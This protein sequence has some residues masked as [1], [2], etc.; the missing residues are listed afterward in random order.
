MDFWIASSLG[1]NMNKAAMSIFAYAFG[2][3]ACISLMS[4][5]LGMVS[6]S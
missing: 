6:G 1:A 3:Q 2:L 5:Y 4:R